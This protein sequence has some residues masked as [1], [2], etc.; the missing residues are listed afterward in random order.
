MDCNAG[1]ENYTLYLRKN[2]RRNVHPVEGL[3]LCNQ[4][5]RTHFFYSLMSDIVL[6]ES[7]YG[8]T[9]F[10]DTA[11]VLIRYASFRRCR[12][13]GW[14]HRSHSAFHHEFGGLSTASAQVWVYSKYSF[15][16][17]ARIS[18]HRARFRRDLYTILSS[19]CGGP[20]SREDTTGEV[21]PGSAVEC[22]T[23]RSQPVY[24]AR[25][26]YPGLVA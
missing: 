12:Q 15:P 19:R 11:T 8:K 26:L 21:R 13:R 4:E 9:D 18:Q 22:R 3:S 2:F 20:V 24:S 1:N 7:V 23:Y 14:S 6:D 17:P 10:V 5:R 16:L 25:G